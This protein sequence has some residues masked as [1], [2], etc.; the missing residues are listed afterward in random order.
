[1][2]YLTAIEHFGLR[3]VNHAGD[4]TPMQLQFLHESWWLREQK[5]T[6]EFE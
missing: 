3:G 4:L 2:A 1:M 5:R 6:P